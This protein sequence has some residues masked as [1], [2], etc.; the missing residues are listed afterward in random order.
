MFSHFWTFLVQEIR[1]N[2]PKNRRNGK[3]CLET[4]EHVF[5]HFIFFHFLT[6]LG[7]EIREKVSRNKRN[8][9]KC[10]EMGES[11]FSRF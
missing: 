1:E 3:K 6:L 5:A 2:V 11:V 7:L 10:L 4:G 8:G 9:K